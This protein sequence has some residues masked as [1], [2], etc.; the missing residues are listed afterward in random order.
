[1]VVS[2][3]S[4][5]FSC[6]FFTTIKDLCLATNTLLKMGKKV[7]FLFILLTK[8]WVLNIMILCFFLEFHQASFRKRNDEVNFRKIVMFFVGPLLSICILGVPFAFICTGLDTLKY[9]FQHYFG[10]PKYFDNQTIITVLFLRLALAF[11]ACL[12]TFRSVA[13]LYTMVLVILD[14]WNKLLVI[15]LISCSNAAKLLKVHLKYRLVVKIISSF[16]QSVVAPV[17]TY[18]FWTI[19]LLVWICKVFCKPNWLFNLLLVCSWSFSAYSYC[20]GTT[21]FVMQFDGRR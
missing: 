12:E 19:V 2:Q 21:Y 17:F 16:L 1:M 8:K 18:L 11:L 9:I 10:D 7:N 14:R 4:C 15:P 13:Y 3:Y 20:N 6:C 5:F